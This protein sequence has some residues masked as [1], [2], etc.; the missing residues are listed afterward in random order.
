MQ[1]LNDRLKRASQAESHEE[2]HQSELSADSILPLLIFAVVK[3]N[4]KRFI[5]NLRFI[6]R[7]RTQSLLASEFD[8]CMTNTQAVA[9]FVASVD[10][11]KL[12]LS[13]QVSS[14]ALE[15]VLPPAL[16]AMRNLLVNNVVSSV[17]ID[18]M[19]GVAGGGKKVAV[20]VYDATLGRLIDSSTQLISKASSQRMLEDRELEQGY[21]GKS[22]MNDD[23]SR[24]ISGVRDVLD[25]ASRQLS[26]EI[27]GHLP[28]RSPASLQSK[29]QIVDKFVNAQV[30]D[31]K[32]SDITQLLASYKELAHYINRL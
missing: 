30:D 17:G 31:L 22:Y 29:P 20:N 18:V 5:S 26:Y 27:K 16:S 19:Q 28:R 14:G 25:S 23:Q 21:S 3:S 6:Q 4:P 2:N 9:S 8:Y 24:V 12:G 10:A 7:F 11:R 13:A 15:R 1:V 32:I